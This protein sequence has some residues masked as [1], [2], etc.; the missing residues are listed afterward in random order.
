MA[1][2]KTKISTKKRVKQFLEDAQGRR[3]WPVLPIEEY[4]ALVEAAEPRDDIRHL[5]AG[6]KVKGQDSP[7]AE[8]EEQLRAEGRL[9]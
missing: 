9:P 4:E 2:V 6:R 1:T 5:E 3:T 7:L 8:F